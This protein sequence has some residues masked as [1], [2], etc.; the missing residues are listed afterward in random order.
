MSNKQIKLLE[1]ISADENLSKDYEWIPPRI[2]K[3]KKKFDSMLKRK[4]DSCVSHTCDCKVKQI[5]GHIFDSFLLSLRTDIF[6]K[7]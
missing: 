6:Y 7:S 4:Q 1:I 5:P 2:G 3:I